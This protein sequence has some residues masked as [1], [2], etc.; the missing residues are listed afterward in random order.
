MKTAWKQEFRFFG[1]SRNHRIA[2]TKIKRSRA[3]I[4]RRVNRIILQKGGEP[5]QLRLDE[6]KV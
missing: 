3:R 4:E 1:A 2:R 5:V 6:R